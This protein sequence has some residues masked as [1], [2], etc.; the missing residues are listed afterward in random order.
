MSAME[1]ALEKAGT[2]AMTDHF[3]YRLSPGETGEEKVENG[4]IAQ[5]GFLGHLLELCEEVPFFLSDAIASLAALREVSIDDFFWIGG[6]QDVLHPYFANGLLAL[7]NRRRKTPFH[8]ASKPVWKQPVYLLLQRDGSYLCACCGLEN[9]ML[10][11]HPYTEFF[12]RAVQFS[13]RKDI[14]VVGQIVAI[15]RRLT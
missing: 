6:E 15:A 5:G 8:F 2:E 10:V 4:G 1:V 9:G 7:V 14:E 13:H 12:H 11:I 3:V